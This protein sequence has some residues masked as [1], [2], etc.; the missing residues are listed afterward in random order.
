GARYYLGDF[1][2][3]KYLPERHALLNW[4]RWDF[5][6]PESLETADGRRVAWSW[7]TQVLNGKV[8][9][10]KDFPRLL[11]QKVCQQ[12]IQSLPRELR[13][14][15]D[16]SLT[17]RP[18]REL[19]KLRHD[20]PTPGDVTVK[21]DGVQLLDRLPSNPVVTVPRVSSLLGITAPPARKAVELLES[22]GVLHE[23]TGKQRDRVYAYHAYLD[24]LTE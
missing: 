11:D 15:A 21:G 10:K 6:A 1:R 16:G 13:L 14:A 22:L 9:R 2:D 12:G 5:F 19:E 17:M 18:L 4:A 3:G 23:T 20:E 24:L 8:P 7:C